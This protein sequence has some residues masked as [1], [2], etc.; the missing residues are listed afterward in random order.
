MTYYVCIGSTPAEEE[1]AQVGSDDYTSRAVPECKRFIELLRKKFGQ[2]P[3]GARLKIKTNPH[4]FGSYHEVVCY[5]D[6]N[7]PASVDY[8]YNMEAHCPATWED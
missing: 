2:E 4:D 6:E 1:C 8:A 7:L 3:D 5:F